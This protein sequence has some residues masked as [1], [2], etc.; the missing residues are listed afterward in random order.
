MRKKGSKQAQGKNKT[1][2]NIKEGKNERTTVD[3]SK[4]GAR[5]QPQHIILNLLQGIDSY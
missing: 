4:C 5:Q 2:R 3:K 1:K